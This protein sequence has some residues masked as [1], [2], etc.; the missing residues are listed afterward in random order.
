[1]ERFINKGQTTLAEALDASETAIDVTA[2]PATFNAAYGVYSIL[3]DSEIMTV[4]TT[5]SNTLNVTRGA[6]GTTAATHANGAA[7]RFIMTARGMKNARNNAI[8]FADFVQPVNADFSWNNQGGATITDLETNA[9]GLEGLYLEAPTSAGDGLRIREVNTP[10]AEWT[11]TAFL[12]PE[13]APQNVQAC[14]LCLRESGTGKLEVLSIGYNSI[15][16]KS[17]MA[18]AKYTN[19]N[20]L[21]ANRTLWDGYTAISPGR[22]FRVSCDGTN[23]RWWVSTTGRTWR[24]I[25]TF[26]QSNFLT[27]AANRI[28][29]FALSDSAAT[30]AG[31]TLLSWQVTD[32]S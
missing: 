14:G 10:S 5:S 19:I 32:D 28:G 31:V 4:L 16:S 15:V 27:T 12:I 7:V 17:F 18:T 13:I 20:T 2:S 6:E 11:A 1:M 22:W 8:G 9:L 29:F 3:I 30:E 21:S 26:A 24:V 25:E 23:I